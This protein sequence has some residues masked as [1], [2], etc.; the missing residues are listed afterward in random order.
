MLIQKR[1]SIFHKIGTKY[2]VNGVD[3]EIA[4]EDRLNEISDEIRELKTDIEDAET[5]AEIYA[6][7]LIKSMI[8]LEAETSR[9]SLAQAKLRF[10]QEKYGI[11]DQNSADFPKKAPVGEVV[12]DKENF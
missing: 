5:R 2:T 11:G 4:T 1:L 7:G 6:G 12:D 8:L 9:V 3:N 10:I